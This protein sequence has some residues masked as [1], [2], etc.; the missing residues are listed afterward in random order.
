MNSGI[1]HSLVPEVAIATDK[2]VSELLEKY[3]IKLENLPEIKSDD[4][5]VAIANAAVDMV[6][7]FTR[8]SAITG[9]D[10]L[11]YRIVVD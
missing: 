9:K 2:E 5:Q 10:E 1:K 8:K 7:K 11:F 4:A 6:L 3:G